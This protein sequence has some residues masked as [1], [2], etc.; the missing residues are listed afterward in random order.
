[1]HH[2]G[3]KDLRGIE[4]TVTRDGRLMIWQGHA[5]NGGDIDRLVYATNPT[6]CA[7]NGWDG[8]HNITAMFQD[9]AVSWP[10]GDKQLRA[11]D[12]VPYAPGSE[13]KGAYPWLFPEGDAVI[14]TA[15]NMPCVSPENP[16]GCGPRRSALS[17]IGYPTSWGLGHI[18][19]GLNPSTVHTVR[20][21]FSSP[22]ASTFPQLP[23]T[24]GVDVWPFFGSN[25]SNYGEI[26]FDDAL[27]GQYAGV[28]HMN[29]SVNVAG[30]LDKGHTPDTGGYFNTGTRGPPFPTTTTPSSAKA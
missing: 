21:F 3:G 26:I 23:T 1:M 18:D 15:A 11:A 2:V 10:L 8:P 28:W 13:L 29:E 6:P 24:G 9:P 4:P 16:P 25:T 17:V 5:N 20:L 30:N 19:G 12:G 7:A 22:G 27:D 14:F